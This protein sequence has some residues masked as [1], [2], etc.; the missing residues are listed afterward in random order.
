MMDN[1]QLDLVISLLDHG[2]EQI[3][4]NVV[5]LITSLAEHPVGRKECWRCLKTLQRFQN[6]AQFE[7]ISPYAAQAIDVILWEP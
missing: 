1:N 5:Q 2:D 6:E 7:Y 3:K 4:L